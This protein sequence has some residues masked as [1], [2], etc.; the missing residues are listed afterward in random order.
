M[1]RSYFRWGSC[2]LCAVLLC[3]L[4]GGCHKKGTDADAGSS[5][6]GAGSVSYSSSASKPFELD[7][8]AVKLDGEGTADD[9]AAG[10]QPAAGDASASGGQADTADDPSVSAPDTAEDQ[11]PSVVEPPPVE[12]EDPYIPEEQPGDAPSLTPGESQPE[13]AINQ[14]SVIF[15]VD[16][17]TAVEQGYEAATS[18]SPDGNIITETVAVL[19]KG[20]TV[21]DLLQ[22]SGLDVDA[23]SSITGMYV[24]AIQG[25]REKACGA[26]S[27]WLYIVNGVFPS[28]SCGKYE[29]QD[30]DVVS[31]RYTCS[32]GSDL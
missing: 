2:L 15:S 12:S 20:A 30:G 7:P 32:N 21:Y 1:K 28:K 4:L 6:V 27:G 9:G 5:S 10:S 23:K 31:W 8:D 13:Q 16:C 26:G 14:I 24:T 18:V 11:T 17:R 25:L 29:L 3:A 19:E 22:S